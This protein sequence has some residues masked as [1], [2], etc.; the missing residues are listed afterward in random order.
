MNLAVRWLIVA[1]GA[2]LAGVAATHDAA[3]LE[4]KT[5]A[6]E[7]QGASRSRFYVETG[8]I[9]VWIDPRTRCEYFL[10]TGTPLFA[11]DGR[12]L[13]DAEGASTP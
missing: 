6:V 1:I 12:Q 11:A 10:D 13:C 9:P 7:P 2:V 5:P 8:P 4:A 3:E